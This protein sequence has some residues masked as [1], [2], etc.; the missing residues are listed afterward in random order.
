MNLEIQQKPG[1]LEQMIK[2]MNFGEETGKYGNVENLAEGREINE[3]ILNK[4]CFYII[5]SL[6]VLYFGYIAYKFHF[7]IIRILN[8][9]ICQNIEYI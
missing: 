8:L 6:K 1:I 7:C 9:K 4:Y 5:K 3:F 2:P